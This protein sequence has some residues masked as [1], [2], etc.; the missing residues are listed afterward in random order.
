[1]TSNC[2]ENKEVAHEPQ[3]SVSL[4]FSPRFDFFCHALLTSLMATWDLL[5]V[6]LFVFFF[7]MKRDEK[8]HV[9]VYLPCTT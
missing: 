5:F 8:L 2:G 4:M 6:C 9:H 7:L 3:A 1:M